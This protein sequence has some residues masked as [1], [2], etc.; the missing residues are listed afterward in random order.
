M[1]TSS[2]DKEGQL[3]QLDRCVAAG[4]GII[5]TTSSLPADQ[6]PHELPIG[7]SQCT[8]HG[9]GMGTPIY[10]ASTWHC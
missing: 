9:A 8:P 2:T 1:S 5:G 6:L 4:I 10:I 3:Q 7:L